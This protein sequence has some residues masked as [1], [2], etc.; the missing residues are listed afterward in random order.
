MKDNII[1]TSHNV[2]YNV[3][4]LASSVFACFEGPDSARDRDS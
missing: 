3:P 4:K 1:K 2:S